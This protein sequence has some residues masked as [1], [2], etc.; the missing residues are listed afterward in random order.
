MESTDL[1]LNI[2]IV[3]DSTNL[4]KIIKNALRNIGLTSFE[5]AYGGRYALKQLREQSFDLVLLDWNMPDLSGLEVLKFIRADEK[6]KKTPVIMITSE[7]LKENIVAAVKAGINGYIAK[8]FTAKVLE[9]KIKHVLGSL[10][11]ILFGEF[12]V[13]KGILRESQVQSALK[14]QVEHQMRNKLMYGDIAV[15]MGMMTPD[16]VEDVLKKQEE[17]EAGKKF[18][19]IAV[20]N[21]YL[22]QDG[23]KK[24]L[25]A[26]NKSR[27]KISEIL[28]K[29]GALSSED[30][31]RYLEEF[32]AFKVA[33]EKI[34]TP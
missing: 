25:D 22:T 29:Q 6:L 4:R 24:A 21:G 7:R 31:K 23:V 5:E 26:Q 10:N 11:S 19:E 17:T 12:L 2:L 30:E 16:Q 20:I 28:I 13:M 3:D 9:D 1:L 27:P 14:A 33:L 32:S 18:G 15:K 34:L 8:P